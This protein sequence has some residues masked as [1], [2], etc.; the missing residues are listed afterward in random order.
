MTRFILAYTERKEGYALVLIE[1]RV[2][3]EKGRMLK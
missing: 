2:D 1:N 3:G